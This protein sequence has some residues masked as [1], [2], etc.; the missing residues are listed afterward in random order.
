[1]VEKEEQ[2]AKADSLSGVFTVV[3]CVLVFI[4]NVHIETAQY[5]V[6]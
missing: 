1:M 3:F 6:I 4:N 2:V 5:T